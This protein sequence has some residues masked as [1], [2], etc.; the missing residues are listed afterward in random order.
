M[1]KLVIEVEDD[2]PAVAAERVEQLFEPFAQPEVSGARHYEGMALNLAITR[3]LARLLGGDL[4]VASNGDTLRTTFQLEIPC[5][6]I[7]SAE[8]RAA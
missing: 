3:R 7:A 1:E 6:F 5:Q 4:V 2:G 8:P